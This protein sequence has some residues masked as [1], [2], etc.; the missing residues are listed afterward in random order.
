MQVFCGRDHDFRDQSCIA[1]EHY[2][3][4]LLAVYGQQA[5]TSQA[6][7]PLTFAFFGDGDTHPFTFYPGDTAT[8]QRAMMCRH[9]D[10]CVLRVLCVIC[11]GSAVTRS[12]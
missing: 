5:A 6:A 4:T 3:A 9:W 1:D 10:G 7:Q 2:I 8:A 12:C 11:V